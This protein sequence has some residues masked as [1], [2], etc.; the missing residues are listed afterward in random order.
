M[1]HEQLERTPWHDG[2]LDLGKLAVWPILPRRYRYGGVHDFCSLNS[3][4]ALSKAEFGVVQGGPFEQM[5]R[6]DGILFR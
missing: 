4:S 6:K 1:R 5:E 2:N 3:D